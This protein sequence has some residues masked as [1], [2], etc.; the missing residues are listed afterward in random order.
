MS[1][2]SH[3]QQQHCSGLVQQPVEALNEKIVLALSSES[4][5]SNAGLNNGP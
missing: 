3:Q 2:F 5:S 4:L 1:F